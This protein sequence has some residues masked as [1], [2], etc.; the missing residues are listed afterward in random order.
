M[1]VFRK[2]PGYVEDLFQNLHCRVHGLSV[3][4]LL[5]SEVSTKQGPASAKLRSQAILL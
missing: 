3:P 4:L 5:G 2:L 1:A